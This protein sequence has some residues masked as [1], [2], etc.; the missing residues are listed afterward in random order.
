[1]YALMIDNLLSNDKLDEALE[2]YRSQCEKIP[3]FSLDKIKSLRLALALAERENY[4]GKMKLI[5]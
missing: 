3:E 5:H 4:D 2:I 1:M